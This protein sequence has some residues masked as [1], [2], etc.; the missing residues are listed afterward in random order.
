MVARG[1]T[2]AAKVGAGGHTRDTG[3]A[4]EGRRR[5]AGGRSRDVGEDRNPASSWSR[6]GGSE[7]GGPGQRVLASGAG[8]GRGSR[9]LAAR[10]PAF[11]GN[12]R[13]RPNIPNPAAWV[14]SSSPWRQRAGTRPRN[15][16]GS[17]GGAWGVCSASRLR[18]PPP[19][20]QGERRGPGARRRCGRRCGGRCAGHW[21]RPQPEAAALRGAR[22]RLRSHRPSTRLSPLFPLR[23]CLQ[24]LGLLLCHLRPHLRRD[25]FSQHPS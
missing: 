20:R 14:T 5:P 23:Q 1:G 3:S 11:P 16:Q 21:A 17:G 22:C 6:R 15:T 9:P 10:P 8:A 4:R 25:A 7:P 12:G 2:M 13:R 19:P 24:P 18:A